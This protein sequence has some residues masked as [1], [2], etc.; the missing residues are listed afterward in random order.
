[1]FDPAN[2]VEREYP[3]DKRFSDT[4]APIDP[5]LIEELIPIKTK[6]EKAMTYTMRR[7]HVR[8]VEVAAGIAVQTKQR[9]RSRQ[10]NH[11]LVS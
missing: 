9:K 5:D 10:L 6:F 7:Y 2:I 4:N 3:F 11:L 8:E 1:M